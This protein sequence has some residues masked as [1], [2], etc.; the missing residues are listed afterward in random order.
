MWFYNFLELNMWLY[1]KLFTASLFQNMSELIH[2]Y[3]IN[4]VD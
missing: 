4:V 2:I 1:D 3:F